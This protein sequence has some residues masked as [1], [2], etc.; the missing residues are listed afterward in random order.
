MAKENREL[1]LVGFN[2]IKIDAEK[3]PNHR[4]DVKLSSNISIKNIEKF[5]PE[6][7]KQESLKIQFIFE[8]T[9]GE[10]GKVLLEGEIYLLADS[11]SS[12]ELLKTWKDKDMSSDV[13]VALLNIIN[14]KASLRAFEVEEELN[15]PI[16]V[17]LPMLQ[18]QNAEE[19]SN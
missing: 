3:N 17:R 14:Q 4:G 16:H 5:K 13:H 10:L 15:L 9:Y 19:Q 8:V 1:K 2:I 6:L 11:K 18:P 12:K 7:A